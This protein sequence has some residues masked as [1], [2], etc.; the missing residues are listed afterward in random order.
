MFILE[1]VL[2]QTNINTTFQRPTAHA[3]FTSELKSNKRKNG[4]ILLYMH[5][6]NRASQ[7]YQA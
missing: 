2:S 6:Q 7:A 1:N 5:Q 3:H 4:Q